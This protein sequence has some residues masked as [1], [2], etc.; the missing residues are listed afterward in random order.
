MLQRSEV[1]SVPG[2]IDRGQRLGHLMPVI[3]ALAQGS[4]GTRCGR[5]F[6]PGLHRGAGQNR[7]R[8]DLHQHRA[9]QRRHGLHAFGELH[10]LPRMPPPILGVQRGFRGEDRAGAVADQRQ[11]RN[12]EFEPLCVRLEFVERRLQQLGMEGMTGVQPGAADFVTAE[13]GDDLFQIRRPDPTAPCWGRCRRRPKSAGIRRRRAPLAAAS[14]NTATIRPPSGRLPNSR[15]RSAISRAPSSRLNTPATHA[16]AYWP[17]LCPS[18]TSGSMPHDCHSRARP[19]STANSAGWAKE[20]CPKSFPA[21]LPVSPSV[22]N[23]TSSNGRGSSPS[24]ASAHRFTV[25]ANT[26]SVSN[27][28]RAIPG[29]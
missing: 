18:T 12:G 6:R 29:Y 14:A 5:G 19:I 7:L 4:D 23:R 16:A 13:P 26:G 11:G 21:S 9:A 27:N 10:R 1:G 15:P 20:V 2:D 28:S 17:T 25:S 8:T 3:G 24:I 22:S